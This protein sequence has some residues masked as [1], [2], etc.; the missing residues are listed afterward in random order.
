VQAALNS[1]RDRG[2]DSQTIQGR[3]TPYGSGQLSLAMRQRQGAVAWKLTRSSAG[4]RSS[5][6]HRGWRQPVQPNYSETP[7]LS[8]RE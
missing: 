3:L 7:L 4:R 2:G 6:S 1:G 8:V 5:G